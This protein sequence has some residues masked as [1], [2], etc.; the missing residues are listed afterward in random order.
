M[1]P[2]PLNILAFGAG[3]IGTY[4]GGSLALAG[5][6]VVFVEQP[7][8]ADD[9]RQRG[10]RLDLTLDERRKTKEANLLSPQSFVAAASLEDALKYWPF[11]IAIFALKSFDTPA[12]LEGMKPFAEKLPPILCLSNGVDNEPAIA[13]A[14]GADKVVYGTVTSA[15]GRRAAGDIVL[16]KLR[17]IGI[18]NGNPLS[19]KLV[20]AFN[21]AY[22]N[23][24]LFHDA[25]AMKWSKMLTNLVA[26]PA[27]AILDLSAAQVFADKR[28]YKLEIE[29]LRECLAVMK[30]Q[31]IDVVDLPKTPVRALA[32]ATRLP[33][34]LSKPL[35]GRAA[36]SGRG[37]KMPSFHID[38]H[39]G[40]GKSEVDYLHGA[41]VRA[42]A[43]TGVPTP[44]NQL[45]TET[46]LA[47]TNG[48]IPLD[49]FA[50]KPE[51][52]LAKAKK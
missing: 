31:G 5:Q 1:S 16:E 19:A 17:G 44:V 24:Q 8:V 25:A 20:A 26:N 32:F 18:A 40:R 27:S 13:D 43:K 21:A 35:L 4:I 11:D 22:L 45:F 30:A 34:W 46:L 9:L 41:V 33:L 39:S 23:A 36:G 51:K 2:S 37:G 7:S 12:A 10:M 28:L 47:L 29:M 48:E 6:R 15:I 49:E 52:L 3:A 42:G 50:G 38:L 14:L